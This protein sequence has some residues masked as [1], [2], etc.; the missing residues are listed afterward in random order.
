MKRD[1]E[2]TVFSRRRFLHHAGVAA[3]GATV[4]AFARAAAPRPTYQIGAYTRAWGMRDYRVAL[5]GMV[6]TGYRHVGLSVHGPQGK[7]ARVIDR[8]SADEQ[9]DAVGREVKSRGLGLVVLSGGEFEIN[10]PIQEGAA[11]LRRVVD[12]AVICGAPCVQVNEPSKTEADPVFYRVMAD[13]ADYAAERQVVLTVHPHGFSGA[14]IRRQLRMVGDPNIRIMYDP[15]NVGFYSHGG[16]DLVD[17]SAALDG[18][19]HGMS[20][21]D[22]RLEP[23]DVM[24]TP[25]TGQVDFAR[26]LARLR[27]GGFTKGPLSVECLQP[28]TLEQVNEEARRA[29]RLVEELV[30]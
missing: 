7:M 20:V 23:R 12:L 30:A 28:G 24:I 13:C 27:A 19:V 4:A 9:A 10:K 5:D 3:A 1:P 29:R 2:S 18:V 22:F 26:V 15:G 6:A 8:N 11:Q 14:H 17:D 21:K 25:G 16:I